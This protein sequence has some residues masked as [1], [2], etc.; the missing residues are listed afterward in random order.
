MI[1]VTNLVD[2]LRLSLCSVLLAGLIG[3]SSDD[4]VYDPA[5]ENEVLYFEPIGHGMKAGLA[6]PVE[7]AI[8]DSLTWVAYADSLDPLVAFEPVD[9]SQAFVLLAARSMPTAGYSLRFESVELAGDT[10]VASYLVL[11]PGTTCI[12]AMGQTMPFQAV[13]VRRADHPVRFVHR[14]DDYSCE[15]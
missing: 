2:L 10:L 5:E 15:L 13:L 11:E 4:A 3:C 9:F 6:A 14:T 7:R 12:T 8:R 1:F